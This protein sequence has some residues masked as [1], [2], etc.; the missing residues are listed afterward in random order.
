MCET[1][2][3]VMAI[4]HCKQ[5]LLYDKNMLTNLQFSHYALELYFEGR[6][7]Q[8]SICC[9]KCFSMKRSVDLPRFFNCLSFIPEKQALGRKYSVKSRGREAREKKE[10]QVTSI[11]VQ[12]SR[13]T[14]YVSELR[15]MLKSLTL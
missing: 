5:G 4:L 3:F 9:Y 2:K 12:I 13:I 14:S 8:Y 11:F 7:Q 10:M 1:R 15:K 6:I